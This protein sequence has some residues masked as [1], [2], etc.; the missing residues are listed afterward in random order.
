MQGIKGKDKTYKYKGKK[1]LLRKHN[2]MHLNCYN[3]YYL[4]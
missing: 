3:I 1:N 4:Q 2:F